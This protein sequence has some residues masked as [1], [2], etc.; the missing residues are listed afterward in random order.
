MSKIEI[1]TDGAKLNTRINSTL[2]TYASVGARIHV[3]FISALWHAA[4]NGNPFY[5][6]RLYAALRSNDQ[7]AAKLFIRRAHAIVGL[8]GEN[9]DGLSSEVI[10]AATEK[11]EVVK[12]TK[13]E[14]TVV[15]GHTSPAAQMLAKLC[16]DRFVSPD[17]ETDKMLLD[18]NNFA[19]VKT[20]GD[21][22]VLENLIK[23]ANQIEAGD[24][25][26]RKVSVSG[27]IKDFL[28]FIKD[29][30]EVLKGSTTLSAG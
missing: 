27:P 13:G 14:F 30:A 21:T 26:T 11:G 2:K 17:G 15:S 6:N 10:Q 9:P 23:L 5:L 8:E 24:T 16:I 3:E 20:L 7:Q 1:I 28:S 18:R 22:Q 4:T 12:L 29:K 19:E 25:D